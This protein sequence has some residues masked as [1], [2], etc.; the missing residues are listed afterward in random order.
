MTIQNKTIVRRLYEE[1]VGRQNLAL[2][3]ELIA[4]DVLDHNA[5]KQ[6]WA[7]G[8]DGFRQHVL[9]FHGVFTDLDIT[10]DDLV[11]EGDRVVAFWTLSGTQHGEM[12]GVA[13]TGRRIEGS[14]ISILRLRDSR[15][16]EYESRPD[17]LG[18]LIQLG[19]F[20]Q[21][22]AQLAAVGS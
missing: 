12:W 7:S 13:A 22:G 3:D 9:Y 18:F 11:T 1:V 2:I 16:I 5:R 4:P 21:Y 17:R 19:G 15:V 20:G 10:V 6:G 8:R 14:T